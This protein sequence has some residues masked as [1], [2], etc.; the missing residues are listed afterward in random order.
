MK[1]ISAIEAKNRFGQLLDAAQREPVTV[2]KKGR[3]AAVMLSI[4]DYERM[5]GAARHRL[6]ETIDLMH[7]EAA[8]KGLT[9]ATLDRLLDNGG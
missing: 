7:G 9:E 1:T 2:T 8:D 6:L 4:E 3:P 5:R